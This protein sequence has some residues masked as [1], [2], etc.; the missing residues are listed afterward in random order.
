M[1]IDLNFLSPADESIVET[2]HS[3]TLDLLFAERQFTL[4]GKL[5]EAGSAPTSLW[6]EDAVIAELQ[7]LQEDA[8]PKEIHTAGQSYEKAENALTET[9]RLSMQ[10]SEVRHFTKND[11]A[12]V[13]VLNPIVV[14]QGAE[15][16]GYQDLH[17]LIAT[18]LQ[19]RN[20]ALHIQVVSL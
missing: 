20:Q 1:S 12:W 17:A 7:T 16:V 5:P 11:E 19:A 10:R 13:E 4:A 14:S 6:N 15:P 2:F 3:D 9:D 18:L 8:A